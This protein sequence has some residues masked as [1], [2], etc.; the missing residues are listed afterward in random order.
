MAKIRVNKNWNK[1]TNETIYGVSVK[2]DGAQR[3]C[4]Y[5]IGHQEYK[6]KSEATL[7]GLELCK[8]VKAGAKI[9]YCKNGTA[10]I[11][12]NEYIKIE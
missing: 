6:T 3:Y 2:L 4:K 12:K 9:V 7:A 1:R 8:A 5:P 10:G 11:N